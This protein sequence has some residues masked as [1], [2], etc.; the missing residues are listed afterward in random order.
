MSNLEKELTVSSD[1]DFYKSEDENEADKDNVKPILLFSY[2]SNHKAQLQERLNKEDVEP[3]KALLENYIRIFGGKSENWE[4]GAVASIL[5]KIGETCK[6]SYVELSPDDLSILDKYEGI[7]SGIYKKIQV[8]IKDENNVDQIATTYIMN[9]SNWIAHPSMRY[10]DACCM[11]IIPFWP[12]L[13]DNTELI[14]KNNQNKIMG[15]YE[16]EQKKY[17]EYDDDKEYID[18]VPE[19]KLHPNPF[20]EK[21][22]QKD[23]KLFYSGENQAFSQYSRACQWNIRR[24]PVLITKEEKEKIDKEHP[25]SY[26]GALLWGSSPENQHY[27]ICPRYWSFKHN[28]SLRPDEVTKE[29]IIPHDAT[30]VTDSNKN[31]IFEFANKKGIYGNY[32]QPGLLESKKHPDGLCS[33]CCF[34]ATRGDS[35]L[36]EKRKAQC[37]QLMEKKS[38]NQPSDA[39]FHKTITTSDFYIMGHDKFPLEQNRWGHIPLILQKFLSFDSSKCESKDKKSLNP[40]MGCLLRHGIEK[41]ALQSFV[42]CI[43]SC[44]IKYHPKKEILSIKQMKDKIIEILSIDTILQYYNGNI[45]DIFA[46]DDY[47]S[48]D[49]SPYQTSTLYEKIYKENPL[50]FKKVISG[51]NHFI[52]YLQDDTITIDHTYLWDI[53]CLPNP[54]LFPQ[55]L[56]VIIMENRNA[57]LTNNIHVLC[58]SNYYVS[59]LFNS[60]KPTAL[61]YKEGDFYEPIYVVSNTVT[62]SVGPVINKYSIKPI[63]NMI[64]FNLIPGLYSLIVKIMKHQQELC[65]PQIKS[66]NVYTFENGIS[67]TTMIEKI[68]H[69]YTIKKLIMHF[70]QKIV[71]LI[72][73]SNK[74]NNSGYV[75]IIPSALIPDYEY[76]LISDEIWND[77]IFTVKFLTELHNETGVPCLPAFKVVDETYIVGILTTTNHFMSIIP[78]ELLTNISDELPIVS[79]K[80]Y[81]ITDKETLYEKEDKQRILDVKKLSFEYQFYFIFRRL[82]KYHLNMFKNFKVR[83]SIEKLIDNDNETYLSKFDTLKKILHELLTPFVDF[84]EY[85]DESI[86][87]IMSVEW[88]SE[89]CEDIS[90]CYTT[91]DIACK[92]M[93]PINNLITNENNEELYYNRLVDEILRYKLVQSYIFNPIS[94]LFFKEIQYQVSNNEILL[95]QSSLTQDYFTNLIP[96]KKNKYEKHNIHDFTLSEKTNRSISLKQELDLDDVT[97]KE[98]LNE[99]LTSYFNISDITLKKYTK[100]NS[101]DILIIIVNDSNLF[102]GL[103]INKNQIKQKLIDAYKSYTNEYLKEILKLLVFDGKQDIVEKISRQELDLDTIIMD[104]A[105]YLTPTD[106]LLFSFEYKIP[107]LIIMENMILP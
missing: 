3:K 52:K 69:K 48:I 75:P 64:D 16:Y 51:F 63:V 43:S 91:D 100:H 60:S 92:I 40:N 61:I 57:D 73:E 87:K 85:T 39:N 88:C 33:P 103:E 26:D 22:Q 79:D 71:G 93:I 23:P 17:I 13:D 35:K 14:V 11:N 78:P 2:G 89:N 21:K 96:R 68:A 97:N 4:S 49:V 86:D 24:Q 72:A 7:E 74:N 81:I 10:L 45:V 62:K 58:P 66:N 31:Y 105:Y 67:L 95:L 90:Y 56:N 8:T 84:V 32:T 34:K 99:K 38:T 12:E 15:I 54:N 65:F 82:V 5:E 80:N 77:Y 98:P 101:F 44:Y 30:S 46:S 104:D 37:K 42:A 107:I 76:E 59:K 18:S 9:D 36:Q 19:I 27:Y 20:W 29:N 41:N 106:I 6:G 55:G 70:N 94:Q 25:G 47:E 28:A 83:L 53:I 1:D 102:S 50:G